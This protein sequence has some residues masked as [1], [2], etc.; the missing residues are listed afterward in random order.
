MHTYYT[1]VLNKSQ[2]PPHGSTGRID[3]DGYNVYAVE[4]LPDS[5]VF[6]INGKQTFSYPRIKTTEKGQ[7]P[8]GTPFYLLVDM[9]IEGSWVGSADPHQL[10][11]TMEI[12]WVKFY[13]LRK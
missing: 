5:L 10:P 7:Y 12:D 8:F 11:A 9:Q 6:S 3:P 4:I 13:K 1:Y 2:N